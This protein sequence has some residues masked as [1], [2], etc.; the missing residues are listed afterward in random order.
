[1]HIRNDIFSIPGGAI[2]GGFLKCLAEDKKEL[3][4]CVTHCCIRFIKVLYAKKKANEEQMVY[5]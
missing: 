2:F 3:E 4:G 5:Q 1:M